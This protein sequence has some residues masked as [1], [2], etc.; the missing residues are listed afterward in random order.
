LVSID[1]NGPELTLI[2]ASLAAAQLPKSGRLTAHQI[3]AL[4][5]LPDFAG[6]FLVLHKP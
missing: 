2:S 1:M 5:P 6:F 4:S 3:Y